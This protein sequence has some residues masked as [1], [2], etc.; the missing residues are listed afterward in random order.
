[1]R[2]VG[3]FLLLV[4]TAASAGESGKDPAPPRDCVARVEIVDVKGP[5]RSFRGWGHEFAVEIEFAESRGPCEHCTL[6]WWEYVSY[7][8]SDWYTKSVFPHPDVEEKVWQD[9]VRVNPDSPTWRK[10]KNRGRSRT[11]RIVDRP[12][13]PLGNLRLERGKKRRWANLERRLLI[14]VR[15]RCDCGHCG[16]R[17]RSAFLIQ[18]LSER[19]GK[20][21]GAL[22]SSG[23]SPM[24]TFHDAPVARRR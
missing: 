7:D 4:F 22:I 16:G 12:S 8:G 5:A 13:I 15:V 20:P 14:E 17:G 18:T 10:W 11:V 9:H 24:S 19:E 3:W 23:P 1:M 6:E 2:R 21:R